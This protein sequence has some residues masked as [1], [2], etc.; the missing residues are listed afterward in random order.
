MPA[1]RTTTPAEARQALELLGPLVHRRLRH[2]AEFFRQ[3]EK[4]DFMPDD[5]L[6]TL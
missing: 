1:V 4:T 2:V 5:F 6:I 3:I